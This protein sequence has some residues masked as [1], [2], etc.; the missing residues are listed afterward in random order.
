MEIC[1]LF[2]EELA[3]NT[4]KYLQVV[5]PDQLF[6]NTKHDRDDSVA[7]EYRIEVHA[8]PDERLEL[9]IK[10]CTTHFLNGYR[11]GIAQCENIVK[12]EG[13]WENDAVEASVE[14]LS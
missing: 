11:A 10:A 1:T 4:L 6:T 12:G 14:N 13:M 9:D 5:F 7:Y 2:S 8:A 3:G